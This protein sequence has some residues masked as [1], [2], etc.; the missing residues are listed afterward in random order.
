MRRNGNEVGIDAS[1]TI[2]P[3]DCGHDNVVERDGWTVCGAAGFLGIE[4]A[5]PNK[6]VH[7]YTY[8]EWQ[9][10]PD[11]DSDEVEI[12]R[13]HYQTL[14][15]VIEWAQDERPSWGEKVGE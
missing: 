7:R 10:V 15:N 8:D 11:D 6:T 13:A 2:D 5:C 3:E 1:F 9:E 4:L 14:A 12:T